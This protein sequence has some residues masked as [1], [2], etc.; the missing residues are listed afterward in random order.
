MSTT[1]CRRPPRTLLGSCRKRPNIRDESALAPASLRIM[2]D[3]RQTRSCRGV[4]VDAK[5]RRWRACWGK[6]RGWPARLWRSDQLSWES[7]LN[8]QARSKLS[9]KLMLKEVP[10][11]RDSPPL[12]TLLNVD[13]SVRPRRFMGFKPE[14]YINF[15]DLKWKEVM[16]SRPIWFCLLVSCRMI[17]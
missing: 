5:W 7:P 4:G 2:R 9:Y 15:F 13:R 14:F 3:R 1:K 12:L 6:V 16:M 8:P 17:A 10:E 11:P